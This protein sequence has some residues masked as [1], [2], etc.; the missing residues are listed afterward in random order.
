VLMRHHPPA[1]ATACPKE[2]ITRS[3]HGGPAGQWSALLLIDKKWALKKRL[4]KPVKPELLPY[5]DVEVM[6]RRCKF[7][8]QIIW[9]PKRAW[10]VPMQPPPPPGQQA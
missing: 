9:Y 3:A 2:P 8:L 1:T 7:Q 10:V 4:R 5:Q 6:L